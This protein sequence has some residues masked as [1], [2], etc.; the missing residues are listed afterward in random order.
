MQ[1]VRTDLPDW[2]L[3]GILRKFQGKTAE[4]EFTTRLLNRDELG[5][6]RALAQAIA[7]WVPDKSV[8]RVLTDREYDVFFG[9]TGCI[10]GI[11]IET[12]LVAYGLLA[13]PGHAPTLHSPLARMGERSTHEPGDNL[14]ALLGLPAADL[15][16]VAQLESSAVH[17][18]VHGNG[19]QERIIR[20]RLNYAHHAGLIHAVG[21]VS[22]HNPV[23]L[24]NV[25]ECGLFAKK[26]AERKP[27]LLRFICHRRLDL[28]RETDLS[29][30]RDNPDS[31]ALPLD[32]LPKIAQALAQGL[33]AYSFDRP[34][35]RL[36][37][38]R[39][40]SGGFSEVSS[41]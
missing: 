25:L 33:W 24:S 11:F 27:G 3:T 37:L 38:G 40:G 26:L 1:I 39:F 36:Y 30:W 9:E 17:P 2:E 29:R 16:Q 10:V 23:S 6:V 18:D 32:D 31:Q 5:D 28:P 4:I 41:T 19:L 7:E 14:G 22:P 21:H 35:N 15:A 34:E 20:F 12:R 13:F 8:F